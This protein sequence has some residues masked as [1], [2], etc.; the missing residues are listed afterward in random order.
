MTIDARGRMESFHPRPECISGQEVPELIDK[1][2]SMADAL[3]DRE[4]HDSYLE[5]TALLTRLWQQL[6]FNC[7]PA[8]LLE[9]L[10]ATSQR[11]PV[12]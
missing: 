12:V 9:N 2:G 4:K 1:K 11:P 5:G 7:H 3:A 6:H 8:H 10:P